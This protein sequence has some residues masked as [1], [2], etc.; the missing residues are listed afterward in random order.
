VNDF[1][2]ISTSL[3]PKSNSRI[4][5]QSAFDELNQTQSV[6]L[7]DLRDL[8]LPI[9]DGSAAYSHPNVAIISEKIRTAKCVLMGTPVYNYYACAS[10]KNLV[11]LTGR[12]WSEKLVGFLCAAGGRSSYMSI[13]SLA[14]SLM[15]DFRCIIIPRFVYSDGSGFSEDGKPVSEIEVRIHELARLSATLVKALQSA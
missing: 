4:L 2:V 1:L 3:N 12:A 13:M 14:N 8:S 9:C 7:V 6:E 11:E 5:C 15:L 10:A